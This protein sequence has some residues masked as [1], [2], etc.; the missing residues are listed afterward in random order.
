MEGKSK[1]HKPLDCKGHKYYQEK[2]NVLN[3]G[4]RPVSSKL[5]PRKRS[6][7]GSSKVQGAQQCE[8]VEKE[9]AENAAPDMET[10]LRLH[11]VLLLQLS[12]QASADPQLIKLVNQSMRTMLEYTQQQS[13]EK[14]ATTLQDRREQ[15]REKLVALQERRAVVLEEKLRLVKE[16][17]ARLEAERSKP[18][19]PGGLSPENLKKIREALNLM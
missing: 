13:R 17:Q 7:Q 10:L 1:F 15:S 16:E 11:R 6:G 3:G 4:R 12:T 8:Q 9:F 19:E 5:Q 2:T 18:E 14:L